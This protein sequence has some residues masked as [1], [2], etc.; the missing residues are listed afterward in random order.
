MRVSSFL[1][2][3]VVGLAIPSWG[4]RSADRQH[5]TGQ[6]QA[7]DARAA[8]GPSGFDE[9]AFAAG[10]LAQVTEVCSTLDGRI[11][12]TGSFNQVH[13][14]L[15]P[16]DRVTK[17]QVLATICSTELG[18]K[19]SR[20]L[21][22]ASRLQFDEASLAQLRTDHQSDDVIADVERHCQMD[23]ES[24]ERAEH[25]LASL[26][27]NEHEI[28]SI[29][30]AATQL[31]QGEKL[32]GR[33]EDW[34]EF[35]LRAP[36]DGILLHVHAVPGKTVRRGAVLLEIAEGTAWGLQSAANH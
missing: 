22:A 16:G 25:V 35:E 4:E 5:N 18:E 26:E 33:A 8:L 7:G 31:Q 2:L 6:N 20:Y 1:P 36:R 13:R 19:K 34:T 3:L 15:R 30:A 24:L 10:E 14:T 12:S 27:L 32:G 29:R 9:Q 11:V 28:E 21:A 17:G 23:R